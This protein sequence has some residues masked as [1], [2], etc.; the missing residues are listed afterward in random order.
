VFDSLR[1]ADKSGVPD[2]PFATGLHIV[3]PFC[4]QTFHRFA[5]LFAWLLAQRVK[6]FL[7]P[8][9]MNLRFLKMGV[10]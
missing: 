8:G 5:R 9:D 6:D 2:I 3:F 10:A 1:R 7:K 4:D